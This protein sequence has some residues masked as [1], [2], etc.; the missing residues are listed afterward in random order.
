MGEFCLVVELHLEGF[1]INTAT[2]IVLRS[3]LLNK[4]VHIVSESRGGS[5]RVTYRLQT[6]KETTLCLLQDV[7]QCTDTAPVHC[8]SVLSYRGNID[9][10]YL[11]INGQAVV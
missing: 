11:S 1:V 6:D 7:G 9:K 4:S 5:P 8:I 3:T 10:C 2:H